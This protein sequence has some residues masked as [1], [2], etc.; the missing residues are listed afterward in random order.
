MQSKTIYQQQRSRCPDDLL[1]DIESQL[2]SNSTN[3][4]QGV[5]GEKCVPQNRERETFMK[6][7]HIVRGFRIRQAFTILGTLFLRSV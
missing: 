4:W 6:F 5:H 2:Q 7:E 3:S 1:E